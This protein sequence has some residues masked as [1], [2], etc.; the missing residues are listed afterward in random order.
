MDRLTT[1]SDNLYKAVGFPMA[2]KSQGRLVLLIII[3]M[4][5]NE[6]FGNHF[7][8]F[9]SATARTQQDMM[10]LIAFSPTSVC[11]YCPHMWILNIYRI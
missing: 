10:G 11:M 7:C 9:G 5:S 4:K 6:S 1:Q 8:L 2:Y 3:I